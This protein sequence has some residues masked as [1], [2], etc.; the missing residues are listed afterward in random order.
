MGAALICIGKG[1]V[2]DEP[3]TETQAEMKAKFEKEVGMTFD[4][5]DSTK[6][7]TTDPTKVL[8]A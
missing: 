3:C 1:I 8:S 2:G 5:P 4:K 6:V 7:P